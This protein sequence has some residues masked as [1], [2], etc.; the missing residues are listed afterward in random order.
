MNPRSIFSSWQVWAGLAALFAALTAIFAKVGIKELNS[1]YAT[2]LR[3]CVVIVF[4]GLIVWLRGDYQLLLS[5]SKKSL[6]FLFLSGLAT[7]VSWLCYFYALKLGLVAQVAAVDKMSLLLVALAG[8]SLLG[9]R[10][11]LLAWLGLLLMA[12]GTVLL[13]LFK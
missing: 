1:N 8:V 2:F 5:I 3:T 6:V 13:V 4:L 11:S 7:G 9:E 10:L 12:A